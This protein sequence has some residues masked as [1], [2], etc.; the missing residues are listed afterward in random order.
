MMISNYSEHKEAAFSVLKEY[1]SKENQ[2]KISKKMSSGPVLVDEDVIGQFGA[3]LPHYEGKNTRA[4]FDLS[5]AQF[6][7]KSPWD[8]Y[9]E[10]D[11]KKFQESGMDVPEFLRV[12]T[13][14]A[15]ARIK[16]AKLQEKK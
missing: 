1:V 6:K 10:I 4:L 15:E 5:P 2:L 9:V 7:R 11:L 14:E 13:E 8:Q 16:E 12:V 3:S